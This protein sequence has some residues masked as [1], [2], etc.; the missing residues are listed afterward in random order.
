MT[1]IVRH[2]PQQFVAQSW[3]LVEEFI[4]AAE[5][6]NGGDHSID[7]I[8]AYL[9]MGHWI[10][11]VAANE[12]GVI[13]GAATLSFSQYPNDRVAFITYM[14]GNM[15][16]NVEVLDQLKIVVRGMGATKIQGA[17]RPA[18]ARLSQTCGFEERY[19]IV[20]VKI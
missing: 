16:T 3:P 13:Q 7:H 10:L 12:Q 17:V 6:F 8:K 11:V 14:G 5:K 18:M 4:S 19:I 20:E 2:I 15:I 9:A 1:L